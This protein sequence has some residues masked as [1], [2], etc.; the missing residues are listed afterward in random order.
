MSSEN[1]IKF[2]GF[3]NKNKS[4]KKSYAFEKSYINREKFAVYIN[5]EKLCFSL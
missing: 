5:Q 4:I 1:A 3:F 2:S